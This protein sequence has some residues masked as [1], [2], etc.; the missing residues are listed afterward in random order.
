MKVTEKVLIGQRETASW[1]NR[2][3]PLSLCF[4]VSSLHIPS[5]NCKQMS[6]KSD[7]LVLIIHLLS[8]SVRL[9]A[10]IKSR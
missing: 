9:A 8:V 3:V 6:H 1:L 2:F 4:S 5:M 10:L 7:S